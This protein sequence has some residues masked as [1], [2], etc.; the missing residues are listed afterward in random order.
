MRKVIK[1]SRRTE[2][3]AS[4]VRRHGLNTVCQSA[5]CPNKH[6]C[7]A[8]GTATFLILG[9]TCSRDCAFC[10]VRA[11]TPAPADE[12]EAARVAAA[13]TEMGLDYVVVT[14][15]TRD[16][17]AD[18]GAAA[19][20]A[21]TSAL[22]ETGVKVELLVPDFAGSVQSLNTVL[23]SRPDVIGHNLE[24]VPRLYPQ[25]RPAADYTRSLEL[26]RRVKEEA[27]AI[28]TKSGLML[29]MGEEER[30]VLAVL[31]EM[32]D[33]K[34]NILTLGQYL[35]PT[36]QHHPVERE[37]AEEE[38]AS[39][40]AEALALGFRAVAAGGFVRSSYRAVEMW[41]RVRNHRDIRR[42]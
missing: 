11:G 34:C 32:R 4:L 29:G 31:R 26:L 24:T 7:Y 22:N 39:Y 18:G 25:V 23:A 8:A 40:R 20:A 15:V 6:E 30:E 38:F 28:I 37:L 17:L 36:A 41:E 9:D 3:L 5:R 2:D 35:Q 13:A 1:P 19:F 14:S 33:A 21:V 12:G 10:A 27:P 16:D 42:R